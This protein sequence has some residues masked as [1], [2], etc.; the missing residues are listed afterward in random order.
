M[1]R[2]GKHRGQLPHRPS[3]LC[4]LCVSVVQP[5]IFPRFPR[6]RQRIKSCAR[7]IPS[8]SFRLHPSR[9]ALKVRNISATSWGRFLYLLVNHSKTQKTN[10]YPQMAQM[11]ADTKIVAFHSRES[12][13]S[14]VSVSDLRQSAKSVD[15]TRPSL[16]RRA[17][18]FVHFPAIP[19]KASKNRVVR[20]RLSKSPGCLRCAT[21]STLTSISRSLVPGPQFHFE[22]RISNFFLEPQVSSLTP[23]P[24]RRLRCLR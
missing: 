12:V 13:P 1:R 19:S 18:L 16:L 24:L 8:S 9:A 4:V 3:F 15:L 23:A 7:P 10:G 2:S 6:R 14:V 5:L 21:I 20:T 11:T 17:T 22:F